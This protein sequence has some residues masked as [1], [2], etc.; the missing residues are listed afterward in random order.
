MPGGV[1]RAGPCY[2]AP[3]RPSLPLLVAAL[4]LPACTPTPTTSTPDAGAGDWSLTLVPVLANNQGD[5]FADIDRLDLVVD[6]PGEETVRLELGAVASGD[7]TSA[8]GLPPLEGATLTV[9]VT[10]EARLVGWGRTA[11]LTLTEGEAEARVFITGT[12]DAN[13]LTPLAEGVARPGLVALGDG[14]FLLAGGY[15][16]DRSSLPA[17]AQ[18]AMFRLDLATPAD[19]VGFVAAGTLPAYLSEAGETQTKR[20]DATWTVLEAQGPDQ[21]KVLVVGGGAGLPWERGTTIS[22]SV[23]LYDPAADDGTG[24][25]GAWNNLGSLA[26]GRSQHVAQET[27][28]GNVV[29]WGGF[30]STDRDGVYG[31]NPRLEVY[32]RTQQAFSE[33]EDLPDVLPGSVAPGVASLGEQGVLICG[34]AEYASSSAWGASAGCL[35]VSADGSSVSAFAELPQPVAAP[36]MVTLPDGRVFVSGGTIVRSPVD[37]DEMSA[38]TNATW[39]WDGTS[40][41]NGGRMQIERLG[42]SMTVLPDG[43]VLIVG[44]TAEWGPTELPGTS[45]AC[46][47][48]YDPAEGTFRLLDAC[49]ATSDSAGLPGRTAFPSVATDAARG[50]LVVGGIGPSGAQ[51]GVSLYLSSAVE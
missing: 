26:R 36:A 22:G 7:T 31:W 44:G 34:G 6:A 18:D 48:I 33:V 20:G 30:G 21:G 45:Y 9:E 38:A 17:R 3:M 12:D 50:T 24:L 13:W 51:T 35:R 32:R 16:N 28:L 8:A 11:A 23:D 19:P 27:T 29:V 49:D 25:P 40:W 39:I 37:N 1:T 47:E 5:L 2:D 42:H 15:G 4:A 14:A 10:R 46:V 41:T 43:K